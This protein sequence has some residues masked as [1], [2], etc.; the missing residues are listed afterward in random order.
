[1]L[2]ANILWDAGEIYSVEKNILDFLELHQINE[3]QQSFVLHIVDEY[4]YDYIPSIIYSSV[5]VHIPH[6]YVL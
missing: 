3:R 4:V 1:M 5:L 6:L 2:A